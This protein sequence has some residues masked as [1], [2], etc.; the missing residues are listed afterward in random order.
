MHGARPLARATLAAAPDGDRRVHGLERRAP[1]PRQQRRAPPGRGLAGAAARRDRPGGV[2]RLRHRA[3]ARPPRR[4]RHPIVWP[5]VGAW[6]AHPGR[7][8]DPR[9]RPEPALRWRLFTE[10]IIGIAQRFDVVLVLTLGALLADVPHTAPVQLIG[11]ATDEDLI[12][13]FDLQRSRYEGP[14]GIVGVLHD[15]CTR[16][17]MSS[18]SLWAAVPRTPRRCRRRRRRWRWS[19]RACEIIGTPTPVG[20]LAHESHDY[21]AARRFAFVRDDDDLVGYVA[22]LE[23]R[24]DSGDSTRTTSTTTMTTTPSA[25]SWATTTGRASRSPRSTRPRSTATS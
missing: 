15:A 19:T 22:R 2:H 5:T 9:A 10:Q 14:T 11:T 8:R 7:R 24:S 1:T 21:D 23:S 6:S 3:P 4:R 18:A 13:R 12:D 25:A 16:A 20:R 17:G